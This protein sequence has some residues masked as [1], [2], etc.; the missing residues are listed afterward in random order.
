MIQQVVAVGVVTGHFKCDH[1]DAGVKFAR[2]VLAVA[3]SV[4]AVSGMG[5]DNTASGDVFVDLIG[6]YAKRELRNNWARV[7]EARRKS[8]VGVADKQQ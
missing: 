4:A 8:M 3:L 1:V 6:K 2:E 7:E 5:A